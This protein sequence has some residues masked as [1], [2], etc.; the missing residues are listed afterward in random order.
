MKNKMIAAFL[1]AGLWASTYA[2]SDCSGLYPLEKGNMWEY[3]YYNKKGAVSS[4]SA[5]EVGIVEEVDGAWE[6]QVKNKLS[7][8]KGKVLSE[9]SYLVK[10]K[11]GTVYFDIVDVISPEMKEGLG[12]MEMSFS[13]ESLALPSKLSVGQTLPDAGAEIKAGPGGVT[14]MTLRFDITDRKVE[15]M[16]TLTVPAGK[17][18]CYKV[19]QTLTTKTIIAKT[20]TTATWYSEKAGMVK[21]ETYDKKGNLESRVELSRIRL[22]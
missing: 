6:A 10:C 17:F 22:Q 20:Y 15:A 18:E 8:D 16:E 4:V 12:S 9:G 11:E 1:L 2:Q 5:Q 19:T 14:I 21:S 7:D 13:G 3:T